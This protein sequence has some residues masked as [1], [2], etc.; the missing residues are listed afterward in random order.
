MIYVSESEIHGIKTCAF[1]GPRVFC[2]WWIFHVD[3][4][5]ITFLN[6]LVKMICKNVKKWFGHSKRM[7]NFNYNQ[8]Y[9]KD[10]MNNFDSLISYGLLLWLTINYH[11]G[12]PESLWSLRMK[13]WGGGWLV[14]ETV[15]SCLLLL[16]TLPFIMGIWPFLYWGGLTLPLALLRCLFFIK[17]FQKLLLLEL[18]IK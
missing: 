12:W 1:Q 18:S 9:R 10:L 6:C 13:K 8:M 4:L 2:V 11:M 7:Y 15:E 3:R 16:E 14:R 17:C 5:Y